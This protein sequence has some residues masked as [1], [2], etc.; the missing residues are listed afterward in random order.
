LPHAHSNGLFVLRIFVLPNTDKLIST[1][2]TPRASI[3]QVRGLV[4]GVLLATGAFAVAGFGNLD[5]S[6]IPIR[7]LVESVSNLSLDSQINSLSKD[8]IRLY[9]TDTS[10]ATDTAET[11]LARLG[12]SDKVAATPWFA[13]ACWEKM[14]AYSMPK[15]M[16]T[17]TCSN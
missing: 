7:Q 9:R 1:E 17:T 11:L 6:N 8:K 12:M 5:R 14:P 10:R 13:K 4:L 3:W 15:S 2:D 16:M